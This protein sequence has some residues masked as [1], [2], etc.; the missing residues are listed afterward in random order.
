MPGPHDPREANRPDIDSLL[1]PEARPLTYQQ[2]D[3]QQKQ[4]FRRMVTLL[5]SATSGARPANDRRPAD[6]PG[7]PSRGIFLD[8]ARSSRTILVSGRRGTGK[9]TLLLSLAD[10]LTPVSEL[11]HPGFE[12]EVRE[13]LTQQLE[14]LPRRLVWLETLDME[15]LSNTANLLGTVLA[16]IEDAMGTLFPAPPED[17]ERPRASLLFPGAQY[18][19]AQ[20]E[21]LRLQ[22]SVA[23]S[24]DG[25]L[26][27]RAASLDPDTF[28]IESRRTE[29][30]R[31]G[32]N[33]R[34]A[35]V[36]ADFSAV[37]SDTTV[38]PRQL[39]TTVVSPIF[40]LPVD[41]LDLSP[42]TCVQLLELLRAVSS[43]HLLVIVAADHELLT[44][45][46]GLKYQGDLARIAAP[47]AVTPAVADEITRKG[48]DLAVN[49][50]RKHIP[51]SHRVVLGLV[52]PADALAFT[53]PGFTDSLAQ[54]L[55]IVELTP[56]VLD[57]TNDYTNASLDDAGDAARASLT[58]RASLPATGLSA[59]T[60]ASYSWPEILRMPMRTLL[61]LYL[62]AAPDQT[63]PR[64]QEPTLQRLARS[65]L[66]GLLEVVPANIEG[67]REP[68][69]QAR[70]TR[71]VAS[72][73]EP[74][75][76]R[77]QTLG[78]WDVSIGYGSSLTR[79]EATEFA[80][81]QDLLHDHAS[82]N[83]PVPALQSPRET[84]VRTSASTGLTVPWPWVSHSTFWGYER[85]FKWLNEAEAQWN[86][87][88]D[89][90]FGSWVAVMTAQLFDSPDGAAAL[91]APRLADPETGGCPATWTGLEARLAQLPR[92][93]AS[94]GQ[95]RTLEPLAVRWLLAV[96]LLCTP[97]MGMREPANAAN[98]V[99]TDMH[100]QVRALRLARRAELP[101]ALRKLV[102]AT[103]A[104]PPPARAS[105]ARSAAAKPRPRSAG[106]S[107]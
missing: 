87:D 96:G 43:P 7:R 78:G 31:L 28:A 60:L 25:N 17:D 63:V 20:R 44:T 49:A 67:P 45:I 56:D 76:L 29:R 34:F 57:L 92:R 23:L 42:S 84:A 53:P 98:L 80:G 11:P 50:L 54:R 13:Q 48:K 69:I 1:R 86:A 14:S 32:L 88:P 24:F 52:E 39:G 3:Q 102:D 104:S 83:Y 90:L 93:K 26:A 97:E 2:L 94:D 100:G 46:L 21:M 61:D 103:P 81:A 101:P 62:E 33:R 85:A 107:T 82:L 12:P 66:G 64:Q 95:S 22:T 106:K 18:H 99:P 70:M 71:K 51:P 6:G 4:A 30:E 38:A 36:L 65:R 19:E 9:T 41:D 55:G 73:R 68:R 72:A 27:E 37:L 91:D 10:A 47:A 35:Q 16:R 15:P 40:V 74:A 5:D 89:G 75:E 77:T 59:Q 58:A 105:R 79:A 8:H